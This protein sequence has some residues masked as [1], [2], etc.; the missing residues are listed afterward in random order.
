MAVHITQAHAVRIGGDSEAD[1]TVTKSDG[2]IKMVLQPRFLERVDGRMLIGVLNLPGTEFTL[3]PGEY[4][5]LLNRLHAYL[6][7]TP[8]TPPPPGGK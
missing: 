4:V 1:I 5:E 2:G 3:A 7:L 6:M 8:P